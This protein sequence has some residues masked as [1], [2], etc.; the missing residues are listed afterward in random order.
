[1]HGEIVLKFVE[2]P[3]VFK[4]ILTVITQSRLT[5]AYSSELGVLAIN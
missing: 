4:V 1:M 3:A 2:L 5:A